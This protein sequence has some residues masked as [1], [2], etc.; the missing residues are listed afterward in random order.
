MATRS[1]RNG[2]GSSNSSRRGS[3]KAPNIDDYSVVDPKKIP[4]GPD[5]L[6]DV[7]VVKVDKIDLEVDDLRAQVAVRAEVQ[8]LVQISVGADVHLGRVHLQIEGVEAQALLKARF[9]NVSAILQRVLISLDRNPEL[10]QSVGRA[11]EDVGE[12]AGKTL[13]GT[14]EA[15]EDVGEDAGGATRQIG[16]G[17]SKAAGEL[18]QDAGQAAKGVG[19]GARQATGQLA[20]GGKG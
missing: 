6:V 15:V 18:G 17:T 3:R 10:L 5:V 20:G 8:K 12:G 1:S 9:D 11:V 14:G 2:R 19:T 7:P 4:D 13:K 16:Q